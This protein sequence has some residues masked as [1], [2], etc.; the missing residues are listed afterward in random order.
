MNLILTRFYVD[1][2]PSVV[3]SFMHFPSITP[4]KRL[5][6][7]WTASLFVGNFRTNKLAVF[8]K[9]RRL[10]GGMLPKLSLC[11]SVA[12]SCL[13]LLLY[14]FHCLIVNFTN[15]FFSSIF[16]VGGCSYPNFF[17]LSS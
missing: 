7:E 13:L 17:S 1:M 10:L 16:Y 5:D 11:H 9:A 12:S 6:E 14:F 3:S 8:F 2:S 4:S 15:C